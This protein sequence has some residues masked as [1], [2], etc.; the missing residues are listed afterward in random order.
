MVNWTVTLIIIFKF[1]DESVGT[2]Q[3]L[4]TPIVQIDAVI[5]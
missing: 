3:T 1:K 5:S 4:L 2:K